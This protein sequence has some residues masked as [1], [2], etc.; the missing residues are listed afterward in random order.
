MDKSIYH[1]RSMWND[2]Q[3]SEGKSIKAIIRAVRRE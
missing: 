3:G 1:V 2:Y